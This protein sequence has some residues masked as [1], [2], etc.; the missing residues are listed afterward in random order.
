LVGDSSVVVKVFVAGGT[1]VSVGNKG[2][3]AVG[4]GNVLVAMFFTLEQDEVRRKR[5]KTRHNTM[6]FLTI[7]LPIISILQQ[8]T[9]NFL[10]FTVV[11]FRLA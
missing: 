9:Q 10:F 11:G 1:S 8:I 3:V 4:G 7:C 6:Y 2:S 5:Q